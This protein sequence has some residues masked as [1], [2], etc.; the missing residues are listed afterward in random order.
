MKNRPIITSFTLIVISICVFC[1]LTYAK[2]NPK[3]NTM[4]FQSI[5][6]GEY[7]LIVKEPIQIGIPSSGITIMPMGTFAPPT[8]II[9]HESPCEGECIG[10]INNSGELKLHCKK[11]PEAWRIKM[12]GDKK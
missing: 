9:Q 1:A 8:P 7:K 3:I 11:C 2:D 6:Q 5:P 10:S 4:E 12:D